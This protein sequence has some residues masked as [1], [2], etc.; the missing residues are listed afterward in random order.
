MDNMSNNEEIRDMLKRGYTV[1][2]ICKITGC[3]EEYVKKIE[4]DM[5]ERI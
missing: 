2:Q 1:W 4:K 3:E 5:V